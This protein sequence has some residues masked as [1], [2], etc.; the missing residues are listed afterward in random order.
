MLST[1]RTIAHTHASP[2][3]PTE[4]GTKLA[5]YKQQ[6][7]ST[8]RH[9]FGLTLIVAIAIHRACADVCLSRIIGVSCI[10]FTYLPTMLMPVAQW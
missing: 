7:V 1:I 4:P 9:Y 5:I 2:S 6:Y 3:Q 8:I 10:Q